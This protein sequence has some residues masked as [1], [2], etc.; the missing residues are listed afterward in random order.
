MDNIFQTFSLQTLSDISDTQW[1]IE[2]IIPNES[3]IILYGPSGC[4]KTF[5]ALDITLHIAHNKSWKKQNIVKTGIIIYCIGEGVHG[6]SNRI[7]AWH[8]YNNCSL[9]APFILLPIEAISFS[10]PENIDKMIA[11]LESIKE[12]YDLPIS[13]IVVDTLS[14][15]SVGYD[16]NSSKD[17]GQ[18]LY[19]FDIIKKYFNTSVMFVHHSGKNST[20]GMRGSSYLLGTVDTAIQVD[21]I[22]DTIIVQI[23]KQK[24]GIEGSF[25]LK[26]KKHLD[27]LVV[28]NNDINLKFRSKNGY[29]LDT[30]NND[31]DINKII[32]LLKKKQSLDKISKTNNIEISK[33][34]KIIQKDLLKESENDTDVIITKYGF[35]DSNDKEWIKSIN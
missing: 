30:K 12:E 25:Q 1:L 22:N 8:D 2:D 29:I 15:A 23:E 27:S 7:K 5:I 24:D 31:I 35:E 20:R 9:N 6:I 28:F 21:N 18:F 19:N 33:L 16:E 3:L 13:M 10:E 26:F 4:G 11:T 17:M 14:K 32:E 34:K